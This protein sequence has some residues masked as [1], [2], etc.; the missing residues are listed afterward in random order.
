[1]SNGVMCRV[2]QKL[3][4]QKARMIRR[5]EKKT[6]IIGDP[7]FPDGQSLPKT[8]PVRRTQY[9]KICEKENAP[10]RTPSRLDGQI[11]SKTSSVRRTQ[12]KG[13]EKPP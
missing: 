2:Y 11:I 8:T 3:P 7:Q 5:L 9:K 10:N 13:P 6:Q 12:D 4:P 1:M